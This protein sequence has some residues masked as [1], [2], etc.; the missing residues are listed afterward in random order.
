[1]RG[2]S[3]WLYICNINIEYCNNENHKRWLIL[4]LV[5]QLVFGSKISVCDKVYKTVFINQLFTFI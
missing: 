1:M 5:M 3:M 2:L 4:L